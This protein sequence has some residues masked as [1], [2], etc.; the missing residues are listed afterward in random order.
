MRLL[1]DMLAALTPREEQMIVMYYGLDAK[2]FTLEE[3]GCRFA[4]TKERVRQIIKG[5]LA[6]DDDLRRLLNTLPNERKRRHCRTCQCRPD[7]DGKWPSR[8]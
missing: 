1:K 2:W 4:V 5:A 3:I 7:G 8:F 6:K